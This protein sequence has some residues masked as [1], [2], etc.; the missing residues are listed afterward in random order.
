MAPLNSVR[1]YGHASRKDKN[2]SVK[3]W[4][5]YELEGERPRGTPKK[6]WTE[7]VEEKTVRSN[8]YTYHS[9]LRKLIKHTV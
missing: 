5:I 9:K 7:V 6:T 2:D 8:D 3:K 4:R 1:L